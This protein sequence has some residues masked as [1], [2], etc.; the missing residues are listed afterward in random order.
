VRLRRVN[1]LKCE[2]L[3]HIPEVPYLVLRPPTTHRV[4]APRGYWIG[5]VPVKH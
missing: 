1:A 3:A 4:Y 2:K 5:Q